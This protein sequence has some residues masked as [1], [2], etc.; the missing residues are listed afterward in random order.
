MATFTNEELDEFCDDFVFTEQ[1]A[2]KKDEIEKEKDLPLFLTP[3][4]EITDGVEAPEDTVK[5]KYSK[6]FGWDK[7]VLSGRKDFEVVVYNRSRWDEDDQNHIPDMDKFEHRVIDHSVMYPFVL[8]LQPQFRGM[9]ILIVGPTGSGKS[10]MAEYYCAAINQ[11]FLRINGRQ[12]MESDN[13]LGRA[14]VPEGEG[15]GMQFLLGEW[16][17]ATKKGWFVLVDEPWKIPAGI[18][19][20]AQ[21]HFERGGIWQ[22]DDIPSDNTQDKQIV[23]KSSYRCV[24]A[25]NVVGTG[26]NVEQYGATMIQDSSTLNRLDMVLNVPYLKPDLEVGVI[27]AKYPSIPDYM[28]KKMVAMLNLLRGGFDK[29]ELSSPA[30]IRNIEIWSEMAIELQDYEAAFRW[31]LLNRYADDTEAKAVRNHYHTCFNKRL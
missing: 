17:K 16:P 3:P 18:M 28:A 29:G 8:G 20:T 27:T 13:I 11:P 1:E 4:T 5:I 19:M 6:L 24:L 25:D 2:I 10:T 15:A 12:D 26:D 22:L 30:S 31:V 9:K 23:P 21:R 7:K 14:W